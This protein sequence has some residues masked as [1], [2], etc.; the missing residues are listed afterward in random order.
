[1]Q[2]IS[3]RLSTKYVML[4]RVDNEMTIE[5]ENETFR[6]QTTERTTDLFSSIDFKR[7]L[8]QRH[9]NLRVSH[10]DMLYRKLESRRK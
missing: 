3:R 6:D 9:F 7:I 1:M 4:F 5:E 2:I 8:L 10:E